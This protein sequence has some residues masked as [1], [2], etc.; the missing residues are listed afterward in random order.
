VSELVCSCVA[1]CIY[2]CLGA[3]SLGKCILLFGVSIV[4][5]MVGLYYLG[6]GHCCGQHL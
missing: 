2:I 6:D 5:A 1:L 4:G 3:V